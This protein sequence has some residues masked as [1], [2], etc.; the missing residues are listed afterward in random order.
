MFI[1]VW[2]QSD[3]NSDIRLTMLFMAG[4]NVSK[5]GKYFRDFQN[6]QIFCNL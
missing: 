6:I 1:T 2:K 5:G 4:Y 3:Y